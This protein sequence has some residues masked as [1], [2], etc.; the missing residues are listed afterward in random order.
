MSN[1][2]INRILGRIERVLSKTRVNPFAT[3][4]LNFRTLPFAQA[5]KLPIYVYGR[6]KFYN[7]NGNIIINA[8]LKS[9]M[10]KL[11]ILQGCFSASKGNA[12]IYLAS[13]SKLIFNGPCKFDYNYAIRIT[14]GGIVNIGA[15]IGFGNDI[16][17]YSENS[18]TIG[19]YCRIPFGT[20]FMDTNFHYSVDTET[21]IVRPKSAPI[22]IGK[23][24]WIGNTTTIM[25]GTHTPNGAIIASKSFLNKDFVKL[26]ENKENIVIAGS[27]AK[28]VAENST[29]VLS[30]EAEQELNKWFTNNPNE[31]IYCNKELLNSYKD[32]TAYNKSFE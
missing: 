11:G 17:I 32:T 15:Y 25:K 16:K 22:V 3:L 10:I 13:E 6:V 21:G 9:G 26:G 30:I 19:D 31:K 14:N 7:L 20:C 27:P 24:N 4:Y 1:S 23:F 28:I 5:C 8:P 12:I 2:I 29:R 18:I